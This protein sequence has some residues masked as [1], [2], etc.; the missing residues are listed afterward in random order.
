[1]KDKN[2]IYNL[3]QNAI[4]RLSNEFNLERVEYEVIIKCVY[5]N[6]TEDRKK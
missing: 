4:H 3:I 2:I 1:M 6:I 5:S